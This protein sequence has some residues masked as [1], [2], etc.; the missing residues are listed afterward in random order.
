MKTYDPFSRAPRNAGRVRLRVARPI[1][2]RAFTV[3]PSVDP[4]A[5]RAKIVGKGK[6]AVRRITF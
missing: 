1:D 2:V 5:P 6:K 3:M 4:R